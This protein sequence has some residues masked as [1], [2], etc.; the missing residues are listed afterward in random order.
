LG[1]GLKLNL[2]A[3]SGELENQALGLALSG[4]SI[5]VIRPEVVV[6]GAAGMQRSVW[7]LRHWSLRT[8][9]RHLSFQESWAETQGVA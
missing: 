8:F 6:L 4:T 5:E 2:E 9:W 3:K 7:R 1:G